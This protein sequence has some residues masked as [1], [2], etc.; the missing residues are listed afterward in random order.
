[1]STDTTDKYKERSVLLIEEHKLHMD[2]VNVIG[3]NISSGILPCAGMVNEKILS[4]KKQLICLSKEQLIEL[5]GKAF[6]AG[7][8][9]STDAL[10]G[11]SA[12]LKSEKSPTKEQFINNI[13]L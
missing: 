1:M 4:Q 11:I 7:S 12:L 8:S 3:L 2:L 9:Y 13:L 10:S 6:E 5:L